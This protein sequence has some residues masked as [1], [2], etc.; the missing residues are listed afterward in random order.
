MIISES[1]WDQRSQWEQSEWSMWETW[2]W[3]RQFLRAVSKT[4]H[5]GVRIVLI[6]V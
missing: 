6:P 5:R 1:A 4:F 2:G 3:Y